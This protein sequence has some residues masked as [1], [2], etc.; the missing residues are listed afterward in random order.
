MTKILI[1]TRNFKLFRKL[2]SELSFFGFIVEMAPTTPDAL[3][4]INEINFQL[5]LLDNIDEPLELSSLCV[6]LR[7]QGSKAAFILM[8]ECYQEFYLTSGIDDYILKP[9]GLSEFR[10]L[11]NRQLERKAFENN[12]LTLGELKIDVAA[13]LAYVQEKIL[14]L[15]KKELE[16]LIILTKKA[17]RITRPGPLMTAERMHGLKKKLKKAAGETLQIKFVKGLGYKLI[18]QG[19]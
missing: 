1:I 3:K 5:I 15:G 10:T 18:A 7:N 19:A 2:S 14:N 11:V 6:Q 12:P 9:F 8:S 16:I 4:L 17:G 13:S